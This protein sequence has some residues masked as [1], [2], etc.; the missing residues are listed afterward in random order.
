MMEMLLT[1]EPVGAHEAYLFGLVNRVVAKAELDK[2]VMELASKVAAQPRKVV[3]LGKRAFY[4]QM[5]ERNLSSAY[6]RAEKVMADNA[7]AED[8]LEGMAAFI[9][10]R[11]PQWSP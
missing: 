11:H 9:Q 5:A 1:G 2:T 10:K 6:E 3:A 8:A 4:E 7:V